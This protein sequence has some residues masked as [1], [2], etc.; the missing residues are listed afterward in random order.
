MYYHIIPIKNFGTNCSVWQNKIKTASLSFETYN[1]SICLAPKNTKK[2]KLFQTN[3]KDVAS[4]PIM[5][6]I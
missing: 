6:K 4:K 5:T 2:L 3:N 1:I